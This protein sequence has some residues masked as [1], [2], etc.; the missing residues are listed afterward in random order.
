MSIY[1]EWTKDMSVGERHIDDQHKKLLSQINKIIYSMAFGATSKEVTDAIIF[2]NDYVD[3]HFTYE[4]EYMKEHE[5]P[6]FDEHKRTHKE[7]IKNN[8]NFKKRLDDGVEPRE[9][10]LDI[11]TFIGQWWLKHIGKE[12]KKYHDYIDSIAQ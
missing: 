3:E 1:F 7:F 2:F 8:L 11:E 5:Y 10:I 9:L 4:E 12:D 6:Y